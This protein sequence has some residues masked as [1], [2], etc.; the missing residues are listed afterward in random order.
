MTRTN[1]TIREKEVAECIAFGL[2]EKEIA[3]K[4]FLAESTVHTHAKNIRKKI[5]AR[6]SVDVARY[7][8]LENP[9][10]FFLSLFF[11]FLQL[12]V[13]VTSKDVDIRRPVRTKT[14]K[15]RRNDA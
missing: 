12:Y 1:L 6:S 13:V 7:Y 8:I 9:T 3:A 4:L 10:V 11:L 2:S 15:T 5:E 14:L